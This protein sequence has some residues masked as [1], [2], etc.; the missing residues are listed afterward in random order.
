MRAHLRP[1]EDG[2]RAPVR[3]TASAAKS[4]A[5]PNALLLVGEDSASDSEDSLTDEFQF[6]IWLRHRRIDGALNRVPPNFY[7]VI[8]F[9]TSTG[10][11]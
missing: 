11:L 8:I 10:R 7:A 4:I 1:T 9:F 3:L 6:G 2:E 5:A